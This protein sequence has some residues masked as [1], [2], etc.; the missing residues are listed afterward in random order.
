LPRSGSLSFP[1]GRLELVV[2]PRQAGKSTWIRQQLCLLAAPVLLLNAEEP[3]VR[4]LCTSPAQALT[5]L[6]SVLAPE[7]VLFLEEVQHL[8]SPALFLKGLVDLA[9][10]R[11][12]VATG[13]ASFE[14]G[15]GTRESLAGRALRTRRLPFSLTEIQ[16]GLDEDLSPAIVEGRLAEHWERLLVTG[17][18]PRVWHAPAPDLELSQLVESFVLRDVTDLHRMDRPDAFRKLLELAAADV[19][20]LVNLSEWAS[21]A[22][23]S[24]TS[25]LRYLEL[26]QDAHLLRLVPPFAGGRRSEVTRRPKVFFLDNGLRNTLFGGLGPSPRRGD[27]GQLWENAVF[28]EV[29]KASRL[30]DE[31]RIWRTTNGAELDLVVRRGERLL[32]LEVK[33]GRPARPTLSRAARSFCAAY[34]PACLG[35]VNGGL[36]LDLDLDGVPVRFRRP[37]EIHEL[38]ADSGLRA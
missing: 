29:L 9:P 19:G 5:A 23:I 36:R 21:V 22:S 30:L 26:A 24:R 38:L 25:A 34:R 8:A 6:D 2:G 11:R 16:G 1:A 35:V 13:S 33:A 4:E 12:V 18:Y 28:A 37:W 15:S 31:V 17:G 3:S 14:L 27:R 10:D 32:A 20:N 7:T